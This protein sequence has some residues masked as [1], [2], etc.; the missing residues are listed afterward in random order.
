MCSNKILIKVVCH[1]WHPSQI[2][3]KQYDFATALP[4]IDCGNDTTENVWSG[5]SDIIHHTKHVPQIVREG[6]TS[7]PLNHRSARAWKGNHC[8]H[9]IRSTSECA[10]QHGSYGKEDVDVNS[11]KNRILR[12]KWN[13]GLIQVTYYD[14]SHQVSHAL[15]TQNK[16]NYDRNEKEGK[17]Q[18][19][20][21]QIDTVNLLREF[22][23]LHQV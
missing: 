18:H 1:N 20:H 7:Q 17:V 12:R 5:E 21:N 2:S 3:R 4:K 23:Q 9:F 8:T 13:S 19:L 16:T 6:R 15:P 10:L 11:H 22:H 14:C